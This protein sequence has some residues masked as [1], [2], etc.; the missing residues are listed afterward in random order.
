MSLRVT[1]ADSLSEN[2]TSDINGSWTYNNEG[3]LNGV[4]YPVDPNYRDPVTGNPVTP[5]SYSYSFDGM[6][7]LAG[8]TESVLPTTLV[9]GVTYNAARQ[10][11]GKITSQVDNLSGE[12][13]TYA[14]DSLNRLLSATAS[15]WNQSF[16]YD[17]FGNL[18]DKNGTLSWHG[19]PDATTNRL[20]STDA[21]GNTWARRIPVGRQ[22]QYR[23]RRITNP[24]QDE[25][26][27]Y[28]PKRITVEPPSLRM[29]SIA[30]PAGTRSLNPSGTPGR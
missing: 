5:V 22:N 20:G 11:N 1:R 29:L 8:M 12:T 15:S 19:V 13:V 14:Y 2:L 16:V 28:N 7:R 24:P 21:N 25:I 18:T 10:N 17:P 6:G 27:P 26:L 4:T 9:S 23:P 3:K 30:T